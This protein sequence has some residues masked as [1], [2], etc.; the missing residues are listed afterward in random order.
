MLDDIEF[1][2]KELP[3]GAEECG[4]YINGVAEWLLWFG[5]LLRIGD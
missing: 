5:I 4:C 2:P 1:E 3:Y